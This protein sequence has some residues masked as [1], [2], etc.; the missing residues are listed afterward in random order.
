MLY[1]SMC[2]FGKVRVKAQRYLEKSGRC[3]KICPG[4]RS[5]T[6]H[7]DTGGQNRELAWLVYEETKYDL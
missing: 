4:E 6:V 2:V 5:Q 1:F 7:P 3:M